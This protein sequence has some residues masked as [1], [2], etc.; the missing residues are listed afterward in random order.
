MNEQAHE[1]GSGPHLSAAKPVEVEIIGTGW[2]P[3][4][5]EQNIKT[6]GH[7]NGDTLHFPKAADNYMIAFKLTNRTGHD[8]RFDASAPIFMDRTVP[9]SPCPKSFATDQLIVESCDAHTLVL[10]NWNVV[11][12]DLRY[13]LNFVTGLGDRVAPLD[14]IIQN[15]GG[16][17]KTII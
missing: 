16:G 11:A 10:K 14:P 6:T 2:N 9:G 8:I 1:I 7:G 3:I 15:G 17:I 5:W 12:M 4:A 13:Q